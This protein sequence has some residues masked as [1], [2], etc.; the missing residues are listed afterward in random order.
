[1][2][3]A[4][5]RLGVR[6]GAGFAVVLSLSIVTAGVGIYALSTLSASAAKLAKNDAPRLEASLRLDASA[7]ANSRRL[8]EMLVAKDKP[9]LERLAKRFEVNAQKTSDA[10]E[11]L[12]KLAT[13]E[14]AARVM[15]SIKEAHVAYAEMSK[16]FVGL[17][18][19]E[20]TDEALTA[21]TKE[22][23]PA[24][25][26]FS[27]SIS[28]MIEYDDGLFHRGMDES[29][30][31]YRQARAILAGICGLGLLLG[32][33][34]AWRTAR[35]ITRP[36]RA[37][38]DVA[39]KVAAGDL[40]SNLDSTSRDELGQLMAALSEMNESLTKIVR[41][42]RTG[43][44]AISTGSKEIADGN[45]DLSH[46]T[47]Q[48]A[49]SLEETASSMEELTSTVK[50]SAENARQANQLAAGAS[51]VAVK[52]GEV[53]GQVVSTMS[54]ISEASRKIADIIGVIDGIAF[55]T[56]ILALNAAVE[57][58]RAGEQGRGFAVVATEVRTL[59]QRSAAAA[60]EI[61]TLIQDSVEKVE[62]G[63]KLVD[64]AGR[65]MEEIVGAVKKVTD[66]M[67]E[68]ASAAQEQSSGI[69][70][71]NQAVTQM[72]QVT[73]QNA[74]L[75]EQAAAAAESMQEQVQ[76]LAR[77]MAVFRTAHGTPT[78][79]PEVVHK[80]AAAPQRKTLAL[81]ERPTERRGENRPRNIVRLPK[82]ARKSGAPAAT[83]HAA[84]EDWSEF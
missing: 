76:G 26:K 49:A 22:V 8:P 12:A 13:A 44:D 82:P 58:A 69:E 37:A 36:L 84:E 10:V 66:I 75:V 20:K 46:R 78:A 60:K 67:A 73:Q 1:M 24:L 39:H 79:V 23:A 54:G 43:S 35:S 4:N 2:G 59:A 29:N 5:V 16:K 6:L 63:S 53:V 7:S 33:F 15:A 57:A 19:D 68:I 28:E 11:E 30:A 40:T 47:E 31:V 41:E 72:D 51:A 25:T 65:T 50:Q 77:A 52:G 71:V 21:Y 74:A 14:D 27:R 80:A 17:A 55:Q 64:Q 42:V 61:K 83:A 45:A 34:I 9:E 56:N 32:A 48:Q 62:S 38:V 70:Q 18:Q 3:L 81:A